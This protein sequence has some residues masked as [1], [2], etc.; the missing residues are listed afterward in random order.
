M[1]Y[2]FDFAALEE[3]W[4]DFLSGALT[5]LQMT[6]VATVLGLVIGILCAIGRRSP[7][8]WLSGLCGAYVEAV[9]NTPYLI[10]IFFIFFG[11]SSIGVRLPVLA[12]A[13]LTLV[14]NVGAY[15]GEIVRAGMDT[16]PAGQVEAAESLGLSR[17]QIYWDIILR[18]A[19]E[20]VYPALT[21]QFVLMM[22]ASS[23]TSQISAEELTAVANNITSITF[24]SFETYI[25]VAFLYLALAVLLKL[26]FWGLA[27]ALFPRRRRLGTPL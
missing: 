15:T 14:I 9:R 18:P 11:L 26:A 10:Q 13:I 22:L 20:R 21:S 6:A 16:I 24:R 23:I 8:A 5:T 1:H 2:R 12:A 4:P 27:Q 17:A 19:L 3:Y 7:R 25:V